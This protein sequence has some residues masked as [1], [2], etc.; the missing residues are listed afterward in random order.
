MAV[1]STAMDSHSNVILYM[2]RRYVAG[3]VCR[4]KA[5]LDGKTVIITGGNTGIGKE[6]AIDLAKR[7]ARVII[8]CRSEQKGKTAEVDIRRES[9]SSNVHFRRL[10]LASFEKICQRNFIRG[11]TCRYSYQQCW[12]N[13]LRL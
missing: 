11:I 4:S 2:I 1:Q 7:K 9:G 8:A 12:S 5:Q 13:V 3:G 6:T 10:D